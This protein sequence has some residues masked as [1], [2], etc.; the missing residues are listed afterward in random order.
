MVK[1]YESLNGRTEVKKKA[2]SKPLK[3]IW[4]LFEMSGSYKP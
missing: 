2:I 4:I 3:K 1:K